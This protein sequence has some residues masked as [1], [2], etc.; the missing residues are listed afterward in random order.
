MNVPMRRTRP[1]WLARLTLALACGA[2]AACGGDSTGTKCSVRGVG[3]TAPATLELGA[4]ITLTATIDQTGCTALP[5]T[6]WS[7]SNTAVATVGTDGTVTALSLGGP[8]TI[9]AT[10]AD[11]QGTAALSVIAPT[12]AT[13]TVTAPSTTLSLAHTMQLQAVLKDGRGNTLT[14]RSVTWATT[15]NT[16][17]T[18]SPTGLVTGIALGGPVSITATSE[19]KSG[20][21]AVTVAPAPIATI[22]MTPTTHTLQVG[23]TVQL[24]VDLRDDLGNALTGRTIGWQ[25]ATAA[26]SVS[27]TGLV[28]ANAPGGPFTVTASVEGRSATASITVVAGQPRIAYAWANDAAPTAPYTPLASW[29]FNSSGKATTIARTGTGVYTVTF[30]G[31]Q[32]PAGKTETVMVTGYGV[33][34]ATCKIGNWVNTDQSEVVATVRCFDVSGAPSDQRFT[35]LLL[36]NDALPARAAFAWA[37]QQSA[38]AAYTPHASYSYNSSGQLPSISRVQTGTYDVTFTGNQR[39]AG[40]GPETFL[41]TAYGATAERCTV[42]SWDFSVPRVRV[43]CTN[44]NGVATDSRFTILMMERSRAGARAAFA[45]LDSPA[46]PLATP[47]SLYSYNS[48]GGT[49]S[50]TRT[51]TGAYSLTFAGMGKIG[52][53][54]ESVQVTAYSGTAAYCRVV[55]WNNSGTFDLTVAV[56]CFDTNG[57]PIDQSFDIAIIQ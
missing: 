38:T 45:W 28:T 3:L 5:V 42:E 30:G 18:V 43:Q 57:T 52:A 56:N 6:T 54:T 48:L 24:R 11:K 50:A 4:T 21:T 35:I 34:N 13:V 40:N 8:V 16:V 44:R 29:A 10:V 36:G 41:V 51:G 20:A 12:V 14:G 2:A 23:Q 33:G 15:D 47:S 7:S 22:A 25:G 53:A 17:A 1:A 9:T 49:I 46:S 32:T 39:Q 26:A 19:G 27:P 31:M 37:D 55:G